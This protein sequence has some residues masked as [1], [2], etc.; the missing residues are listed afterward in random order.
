[1]GRWDRHAAMLRVVEDWEASESVPT[2]FKFLSEKDRRS[3]AVS[4]LRVP[5]G[6]N[7]RFLAK[8]LESD[9]FQVGTGYGNLKRETIRIG[10]MG[11]H[12]VDE[13]TDLLASIS[14]FI[15]R[16]NSE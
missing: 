14:A 12:T 8:A 6:Y 4:C 13:V 9:G 10:H 1:M 15:L 16:T 5:R 7:S 2:G 3:W 11:D